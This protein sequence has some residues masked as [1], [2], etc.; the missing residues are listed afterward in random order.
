MDLFAL[1]TAATLTALAGVA[2]AAATGELEPDAPLF[3]PGEARARAL[4]AATA[5]LLCLLAGLVL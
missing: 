5:C 3:P 1:I 4:M 2:V